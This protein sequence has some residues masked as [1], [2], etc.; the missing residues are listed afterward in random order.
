MTRINRPDTLLTELREIR[1]RLRLLEGAGARSAAVT[2]MTMSVP[3]SSA[4]VTAVHLAPA[5]PANW[6]ATT[7]SNWQGLLTTQ[8]LQLPPGARLVVQAVAGSKTTG[9][10]RALMAGEPISDQLA[11]APELMLHTI[12]LPAAPDY[13]VEVV[14]QARRVDGRSA[15]RVAA[16]LLPP[17]ASTEHPK[18]R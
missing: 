2:S 17:A 6:P 8:L 15:I 9:H 11:V 1:R 12:A 4:L 5:R 14:V 7:S 16:A 10:V 3:V 18:E 13:P